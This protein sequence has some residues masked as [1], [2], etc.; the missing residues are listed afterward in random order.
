M[1][2]KLYLMTEAQHTQ[3]VVA[4]G[5]HPDF[6]ADNLVDSATEMLQ[7]LPMVE[8]EPAAWQIKFKDQ[9]GTQRQ[10]TYT[11][12]AIGDYRQIDPNAICDPLYTSPQPLQPITAE[13]V[14]DQMVDTKGCT[15]CTKQKSALENLGMGLRLMSPSIGTKNHIRGGA[16]HRLAELGS[17]QN[18][19]TRA[20]S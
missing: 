8:G 13:D 15:A 12:N 17:T 18:D 5:I 10:V 14:T 16:A 1:T 7:S 2:D 4:L 11:H 3:L 19:N 6:D 9:N 20:V